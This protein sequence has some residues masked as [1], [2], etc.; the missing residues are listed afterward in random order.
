MPVNELMTV[1]GL[2]S[3]GIKP[4]QSWC[5]RRA[6]RSR[7]ADAAKANSARQAPVR[8]A[9]LPPPPGQSLAPAAPISP[10]PL[11]SP[12]ASDWNSAAHG[13]AGD[14]L[15]AI[16][17]ANRIP[18]T[19]LQQVNGIADPTKVKPGTILKIPG[20]TTT[21]SAAAGHQRCRHRLRLRRSRA[22]PRRLRRRA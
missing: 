7:G 15:Y 14:S 12:A 17:R 21:A 3:P 5:C 20:R 22:P 11:P 1:N 19:Q 16:A 4:G 9:A 18:L 2:T 8:V 13:E 10:I 6:A